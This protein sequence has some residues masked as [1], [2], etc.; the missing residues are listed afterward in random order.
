MAIDSALMKSI[1]SIIL[2]QGAFEIELIAFER[3]SSQHT[4]YEFTGIKSKFPEREIAWFQLVAQLVCDVVACS[5]PELLGHS[6]SSLSDLLLIMDC[7]LWL[8][9]R[10]LFLT[11]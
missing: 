6:F 8:I 2:S 10:A 4:R 11:L 1:I 7:S 9:L 3:V 5:P